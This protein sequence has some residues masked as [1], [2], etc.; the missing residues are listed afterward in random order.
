MISRAAGYPADLSILNTINVNNHPK[1]KNTKWYSSLPSFNACA[2]YFFSIATFIPSSIL[3]LKSRSIDISSDVKI[4][5]RSNNLSHLCKTA[6][7]T[8]FVVM[9]YGI[10][11]FFQSKDN[12][13]IQKIPSSTDLEVAAVTYGL[14]IVSQA[15]RTLLSSS[16]LFS[17]LNNDSITGTE[18]VS[19]SNTFDN[20]GFF[21][22]QE[23][24][25][26]LISTTSNL[27]RGMSLKI[28]QMRVL[29]Q[30]EIVSDDF[31]IKENA[32]YYSEVSLKVYNIE[33]VANP[34]L[35]NVLDETVTSM[36]VKGGLLYTIGGN[37]LKVFDISNP[38]IPI[39]LGET[40]VPNIQGFLCRTTETSKTF[41]CLSSR[42]FHCIDVSNP[43]KPFIS[44][45][46]IN[47]AWI[48]RVI[49]ALEDHYF[50]VASVHEMQIDRTF[51]VAN[52]V[53]S[54]APYFCQQFYLQRHT[55][56]ENIAC[57]DSYC[58]ISS[59]F[60]VDV[61][62]PCETK[63]I[64]PFQEAFQVFQFGKDLMYTASRN[65]GLGI[66]SVKDILSP[67]QIVNNLFL[68]LGTITKIR[69]L[70]NGN[71]LLGDG[72][73]ISI[74]KIEDSFVISGTPKP[75]SKG[76][77]SI[78]LTPKTLSG[79]VINTTKTLAMHIL[80]A[81]TSAIEI[82]SFVAVVD[83]EF[84]QS[85]D[86]RSFKHVLGSQLTYHLECDSDNNH[87]NPITLNPISGQFSGK[88]TPADLGVMICF[89]Q[90]MD[91]LSASANS[92][93]F[94]I[95]TF[96]GP[97]SNPILNQLAIIGQPFALELFAS[98][99][100]PLSEFKFQVEGLPPS[101]IFEND[102]IK[103]TPTVSDIGSF[104]ITITTTDQN[105]ISVTQSLFLNCVAP[106]APLF[107]HYFSSQLVV[108]GTEFI[109]PVP[110]DIAVNPTHPNAKINYFAT[111]ANGSPLP[112]WINFDG[113]KFHGTPPSTAKLYTDNPFPIALIAE[114]VYSNGQIATSTTTF[115]IT[116]TGTS[117]I[118]KVS[119]ILTVTT[120]VLAAIRLARNPTAFNR[121]IARRPNCISLIN[122]VRAC[123]C[124][125]CQE[126][127]FYKEDI[128]LDS[129]QD[130]SF[131][132]TFR[133]ESDIV[134]FE[135]L[136]DK[137]LCAE[138][139]SWLK[140]DY[141]E[142]SRRWKVCIES[143]SITTLDSIRRITVIAINERGYHLEEVNFIQCNFNSDEMEESLPIVSTQ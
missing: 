26:L 73:T 85:L 143:N 48:Y 68:N 98:S 58:Y 1:E 130:A 14:G 24:G 94:N 142:A 69:L 31:A 17:I 77:Y 39:L 86:P 135:T 101:F 121:C 75:G 65:N 140:V 89:I 37:M 92:S 110:S 74:A 136:R 104:P 36:H 97:S 71:I 16:P 118:Q 114:Q 141:D 122:R 88:P 126:V 78:T 28:S 47:R 138:R 102:L 11:R 83:R 107:L 57:K 34:F 72:S 124:G 53:N 22:I 119:A 132:Y 112:P 67:S 137:K 18:E 50:I 52:V 117:L 59:N 123:F 76:N 95:S 127:K 82:P 80:P 8:T 4:E 115:N 79:R 45:E 13:S 62:I 63:V 23:E 3:P 116:V 27:P 6:V 84:T 10:F 70:N 21:P 106:S 125:L 12:F 20:W 64:S 113:K 99:P 66:L 54:S 108:I 111:L 29:N 42:G 90:A 128:V 9:T 96:F 41:G 103:G 15:T 60:I 134:R 109:I 139:P 44:G 40:P 133:T 35:A 2:E 33:D 105:G 56:G 55:L 49:A 100:D 61:H 43:L 93:F 46:I 38:F 91:S 19:F 87:P 30:L 131:E 25:R 120:T 81:I 32:L 129:D 51:I 7:V 5:N